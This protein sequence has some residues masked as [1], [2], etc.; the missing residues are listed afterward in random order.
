MFSQ[1]NTPYCDLLQISTANIQKNNKRQLLQKEFLPLKK[2][3][4]IWSKN[5][6]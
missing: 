3:I 6:F 4:K 2:N 5:I 1:R